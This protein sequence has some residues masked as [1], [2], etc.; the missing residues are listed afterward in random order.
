MIRVN[1]DHDRDDQTDLLVRALIELFAEAHDVDAVLAQCGTYGRCRGCFAGGDLQLHIT[2]DLF[3]HCC[4]SYLFSYSCGTGCLPFHKT[5]RFDLLKTS[6][7]SDRFS[8][9]A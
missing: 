3:C 7:S 9:P 5:L 1:R 6:F 8:V 4:F 2:C